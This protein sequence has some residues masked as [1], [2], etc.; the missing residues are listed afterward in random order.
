MGLYAGFHSITMK[1]FLTKEG[2]TG[3]LNPQLLKL[4]DNDT[5]IWG[6]KLWYYLNHVADETPKWYGKF[7]AF[8]DRPGNFNLSEHHH[9]HM[10][11]RLK[12][13]ANNRPIVYYD[14]KLQGAHHIH[15]RGDAHYRVLQHHYGNS[16]Y[17]WRL[18]VLCLLCCDFFVVIF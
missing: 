2:S 6:S 4:P 1:E 17:C 15:I 10:K 16:N 3:G 18:V 7:I 13:F 8:P 12:K 11:E 9:P 14:D 5:M